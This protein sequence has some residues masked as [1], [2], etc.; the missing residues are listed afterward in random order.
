MRF[1]LYNIRYAAGI[2]RRFHLPL[3]FV[4][5]F[6]R[7]DRNLADIIEFID[8]MNPDIV[9]LVEVDIGSFR[10]NRRNQARALADRISHHPVFQSKYG[11]GSVAEMLPIL[12]KQGN[13]L[14]TNQ[15]IQSSRFHYLNNGVKRL[16]IEIELEEA[17]IFLVHLSLRYRKRQD[18]L[19][20][21]FQLI[22]AAR[23]PVIVAGD[24]NVFR[25]VREL[26]LFKAA[27]GLESANLEGEPS[28][29]SRAPKRQLDYILHS[30]DIHVSRF[31]VPQVTFS[32]H[33]PLVC[34]FD[35]V[36]R[37]RNLAAQAVRVP[38][39]SLGSDAISAAVL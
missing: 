28:H 27:A 23:K 11:S 38:V 5:Y 21:L 24:F 30:R 18:Q 32:D 29:P 3:P 17:N 2:G 36:S 9:G 22:D 8:S 19:S 26:E 35:I 39:E 33:V 25:G 16:V 34:D 12:S 13:A 37:D 31:F 7:T 10:T 1:L 15:A 14:L 4:G 20:D 6:K